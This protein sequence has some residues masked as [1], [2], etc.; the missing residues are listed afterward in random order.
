MNA[1]EILINRTMIGRS[2]MNNLINL[3]NRCSDSNLQ[4]A[5]IEA[6]VWLGG[7]V[8]MMSLLAKKENKGREVHAFDSF[9]GLPKPEAID[10]ISLTKEKAIDHIN[11]PSAYSNWCTASLDDFEQ[12]FK[13]IGLGLDDVY[14]HKGFFEKTVPG[15]NK[16][17]AILRCDAD[18]YSSTTTLLEG[19]YEHVVPGGYLIFDDYGYWEGCKKAVDDFMRKNNIDAT[20]VN[21]DDIEHWFQKPY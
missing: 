9:E 5:F 17:I 12:T 15:W 8:A 19:L 14:I 7:A 4:G 21:T 10:V 13:M 6:G 18:W 3:C 2:R 20:L 16:P 1:L 11:D